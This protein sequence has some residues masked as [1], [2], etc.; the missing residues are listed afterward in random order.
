MKTRTKVIVV[1]ALAV[2]AAAGSA[3]AV[4]AAT[5]DTDTPITGEA[6][7]RAETAALAQVG[8]GRVTGTEAGDEEGYYQV[9]VTKDDGTQ[10]DVNLDKQFRVIKTKVDHESTQDTGR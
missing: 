3:G 5:G 8:S 1:S 10:V 4:V 6:R 9:E 7:Q 2:A